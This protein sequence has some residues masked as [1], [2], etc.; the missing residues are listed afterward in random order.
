MTV[1]NTQLVS[2][3][4]KLEHQNKDEKSAIFVYNIIVG[5]CFY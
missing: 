3:F 4:F 5:G 2:A 1:K